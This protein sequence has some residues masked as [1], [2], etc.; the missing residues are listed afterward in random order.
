MY[1]ARAV[2]ASGDSMQETGTEHSSV[3]QTTLD[4]INSEPERMRLRIV[5][6]ASDGEARRGASFNFLTFQHKLSTDSP[7][8]Q[9]LSPLWFMDFYVG[10]DDLTCDK[11]WKHIFKRFHNLLL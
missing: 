10:Y 9:M 4:G 2:I 6:I 8:Y 7:I 11:D 5:S 1:S 3:I